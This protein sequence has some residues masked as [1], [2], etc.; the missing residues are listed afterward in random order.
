VK[1]RITDVTLRDGSHPLEHRLTVERAV[2]IA[3][4]LIGAGVP[5]IEVSH[6]D[7]LGG[8]SLIYGFSLVDEHRLIACTSPIAQGAGAQLSVLFLPGIGTSADLERAAEEGATVARIAT[9]STEANLAVQHLTKACE[10]GMEPVGFLM[11][12]HM[13]SPSTLAE[14]ARIQEAAGARVVYCTDTAGALTPSSTAARVAALREALEPETVVGFHAHNNLGLAVGNTIRA[15]EEGARHV[16]ASLRSLG[17]GAGNCATEVLVAVCESLDWETGID[18]MAVAD[19]AE[20]LVAPLG[21]GGV[22]D[23]ASLL[24]GWTGVGNS[25]LL[26]ARRA[27]DHYGIKDTDI[28]IEAGRRH[29]V[30]GQEDM[31]IDIA[32]QLAAGVER[33][34]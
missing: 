22:I 6:G 12:A 13:A 34:P 20:D 24:M 25:L 10:L 18:V 30:S 15:I 2:A 28:L 16:D 32:L 8:S 5:V 11:M 23:R 7:G 1:V 17:A 19:A 14:Q 29:L 9:H 27:A 21:S 26:P 3:G 4:A 31:I 33:R